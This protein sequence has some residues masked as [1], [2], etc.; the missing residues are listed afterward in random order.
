MLSALLSR[1]PGWRWQFSL[2]KRLNLVPCG[3]SKGDHSSHVQCPTSGDIIH[4]NV[5]YS[6]LFASFLTT[7][8][9]ALAMVVLIFEWPGQ[10]LSV[11]G[12]GNTLPL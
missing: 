3:R 6:L 7:A 12:L 10:T 5:G 1:L 11:L 4:I 2:T 9:V 8:E